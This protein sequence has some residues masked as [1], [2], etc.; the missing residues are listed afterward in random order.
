MGLRAKGM[1]VR[2]ESATLIQPSTTDLSTPT[3]VWPG[4]GRLP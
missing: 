4:P 3:A 2:Q 1:S